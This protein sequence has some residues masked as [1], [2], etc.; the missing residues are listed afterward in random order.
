[1]LETSNLLVSKNP[2]KK[3]RHLKVKLN[4]TLKINSY[5]NLNVKKYKY[6]S[7][8]INLTDKKGRLFKVKVII[9][10][11]SAFNLI[12]PLLIN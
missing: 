10:N 7:I 4:K 1:V 11:R 2:K 8:N 12:Y 5:Y 9:N 3:K 6:Y